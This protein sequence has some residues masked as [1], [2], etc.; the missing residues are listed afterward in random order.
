MKNK[1]TMIVKIDLNKQ[2]VLNEN[3]DA[4]V[5]NF[6]KTGVDFELVLIDAENLIIDSNINTI[7]NQ[8]IADCK[9]PNKPL[10][11]EGK[12][13]KEF[14]EN[15]MKYNKAMS[16]AKP[17]PTADIITIDVIAPTK[18]SFIVDI[19]ANIVDSK[20]FADLMNFGP[21]YL[22]GGLSTEVIINYVLIPFYWFLYKNDL[23]NDAKCGDLSKYKFALH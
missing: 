5:T 16:S 11:I 9:N 6:I 17:A 2:K 12:L 10:A 7:V 19:P 21:D 3:L 20:K 8:Y 23:L 15:F 18:K 1:K 4:I 14:I 22:M 13:V